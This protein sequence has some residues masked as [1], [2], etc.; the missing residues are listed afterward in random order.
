MEEECV[1][2]GEDVVES[3]EDIPGERS[4]GHMSANTMSDH[5]WCEASVVVALTEV[6]EKAEGDIVVGVT[7]VVF[8]G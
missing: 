5:G 6:D 2:D 7:A 8:V 4:I 1:E 3:E